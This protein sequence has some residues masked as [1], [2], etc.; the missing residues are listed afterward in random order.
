[1]STYFYKLLRGKGIGKG[2][3]AERQ[4]GRKQKA[5]SR[6][7]KAEGRR[8]KAERQKTENGKRKAVEECG[9]ADSCGVPGREC[10]KKRRKDLIQRTRRTFGS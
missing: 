5:E 2:R 7:Q 10:K 9:A 4:K 1:L 6:R 8:Q 3:K